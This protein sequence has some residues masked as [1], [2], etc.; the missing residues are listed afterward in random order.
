M[1]R[2]G[3]PGWGLGMGLTTPHYKKSNGV[4]D[5]LKQSL[6]WTDSLDK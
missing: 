1:A 6:A 3:P 4:T 5:M 2:G